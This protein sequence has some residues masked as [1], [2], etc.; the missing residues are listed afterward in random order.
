MNYTEKI[1]KLALYL[2]ASTSFLGATNKNNLDNNGK[3]A[4]C[5]TASP[6]NT[7]NLT[8]LYKK[9]NADINEVNVEC[10]TSLMLAEAN[11]HKDAT[12][13]LLRHKANNIITNDEGSTAQDYA[14]DDKKEIFEKIKEEK[15][16]E[17][18][19]FMKLLNKSFKVQLIQKVSMFLLALFGIGIYYYTSE[20]KY[21]DSK[22]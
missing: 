20:N 10:N 9:E 8:H 18:T 12:E 13:K 7:K 21:K 3:I 19:E 4:L 1:N 22:Q 16:N 11:C 2:I 5:L 17:I 14:N 15:D 6:G